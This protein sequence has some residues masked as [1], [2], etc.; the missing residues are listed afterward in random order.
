MTYTVKYK[1]KG[2]FFWKKIGSVKGDGIMPDSPVA[3]RFF[4]TDKEERWEI[5]VEGTEFFFSQERFVLIKQNME[6]EARQVI[7]T[8]E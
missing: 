3:T 4:I 6:T 7:R 8:K 1:K 5:P 2:Q